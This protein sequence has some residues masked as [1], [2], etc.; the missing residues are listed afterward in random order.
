MQTQTI[1][2]ED[3]KLSKETDKLGQTWNNG[4]FNQ[5]TKSNSLQKPVVIHKKDEM[6]RT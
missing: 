5:T 3:L 2:K 4:I 6:N 1:K